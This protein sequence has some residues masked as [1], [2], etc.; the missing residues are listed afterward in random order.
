LPL[1]V[2]FVMLPGS[3]W[4][5]STIP[6][7]ALAK[8]PWRLLGFAALACAALAGAAVALWQWPRRA[9]V[10]STLAVIAIVLG[11]AVYLYPP[12]PFVPYGPEGTPSLADQVRF[13]RTT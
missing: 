2:V 8:F 11:S 13:E 9:V 12:K 7:L 1:L 4:L 6:L 3:E 10:L 5:W